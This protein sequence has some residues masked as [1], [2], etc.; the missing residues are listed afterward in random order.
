[1]ADEKGASVAW[2][3]CDLAKLSG[4]R[5]CEVYLFRPIEEGAAKQDER[6]DLWPVEAL[7]VDVTLRRAARWYESETSKK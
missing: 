1:M 5:P 3:V 2:E 7:A 6:R 4:R